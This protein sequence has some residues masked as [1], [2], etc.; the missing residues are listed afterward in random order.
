MSVTFHII[1]LAASLIAAYFRLTEVVERRGMIITPKFVRSY[2]IS[3][4]LI[5]GLLSWL[6][7]APLDHLVEGKPWGSALLAGLAFGIG[8]I[9]QAQLCFGSSLMYGLFL[10]NQALSVYFVTPALIGFF[11]RHFLLP[12]WRTYLRRRSLA[13]LGENF[14]REARYERLYGGVVK[15]PGMHDRV[16]RIAS[17]GVGSLPFLIALF[18]APWRADLQ[19]AGLL[20][21][22]G[23]VISANY[24]LMDFALHSALLRDSRIGARLTEIACFA[25]AL[26]LAAT[27]IGR[28]IA[29]LAVRY[30]AAA[31]VTLG[32]I[33]ALMFALRLGLGASRLAGAV[34][35][36]LLAAR[37]LDGVHRVV[38]GKG[39]FPFLAV[40][41]FYPDLSSLAGAVLLAIVELGF[42]CDDIFRQKLRGLR[43]S[44]V[45]QLEAMLTC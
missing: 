6:M 13:R 28:Y 16:L 18:V 33:I 4:A 45:S 21:L 42:T 10:N 36:R 9:G 12:H 32:T 3:A 35:R 44:E 30:P 29:A 37:V 5:W 40:G 7:Q 43:A 1:L 19:L 20:V 41:V 22:G 23:V 11:L 31:G 39:V 38:L 27:S 34:R 24:W 25:L 17:L 8:V 15:Q 2:F 14:A 26:I